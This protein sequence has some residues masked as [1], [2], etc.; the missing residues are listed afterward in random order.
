MIHDT[1]IAEQRLD[2]VVHQIHWAIHVLLVLHRSLGVFLLHLLPLPSNDSLDARLL[3][4]Q[5][6]HCPRLVR[7]RAVACP[8]L[9]HQ[10]LARQVH[11]LGVARS[12]DNR[13]AER[14]SSSMTLPHSLDVHGCA[15]PY[16]V[17]PVAQLVQQGHHL[18]ITTLVISL[19]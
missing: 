15:V 13:R 18:C 12:V 6:R 7:W 17:L 19:Q 4:Q 16:Q 1:T 14:P 2:L 3:H 5:L 8:S 9:S 10:R 11:G